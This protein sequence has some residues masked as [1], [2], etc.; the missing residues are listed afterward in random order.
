MKNIKYCLIILLMFIFRLDV[1]ATN[2]GM[3]ISC[4][5]TAYSGDNISCTVSANAS[6]GS[7][8]GIN[9]NYSIENA[10]FQSFNPASGWSAYNNSSNGFAI[11]NINGIS[12]NNTVGTLNIHIDGIAGS[13]SKIGLNNI[14]AS[15]TDY[16]DVSASNATASINI[17]EKTSD[18]EK[19][20]DNDKIKFGQDERGP[21]MVTTHVF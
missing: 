7:I 19:M 3:N 17:I 4:P 10:S 9:A 6:D 5:S 1:S 15:D 14:G 16:N 12:G 13:T 8:N 21:R 2:L 11:G 20:M 18:N